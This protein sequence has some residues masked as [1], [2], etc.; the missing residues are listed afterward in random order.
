[1]ADVSG[2]PFW[3]LTSFRNNFTTSPVAVQ[4]LP[5]DYSR[6][7]LMNE[8]VI[9]GS[10][11]IAYLWAVVIHVITSASIT[12]TAAAA[13]GPGS[14]TTPIVNV[15]LLSSLGHVFIGLLKGQGNEEHD[16]VCPYYHGL[17]ARQT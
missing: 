5:H 3:Y 12:F 6:S 11:F 1:M 4:D 7:Q 8:P 10:D 13:G 16:A 14:T 15:G 2:E 17:R 9:E